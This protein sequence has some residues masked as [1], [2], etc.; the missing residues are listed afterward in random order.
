MKPEAACGANDRSVE[1]LGCHE[2]GDT[3]QGHVVWN[4]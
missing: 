1:V 2:V 4:G 3:S